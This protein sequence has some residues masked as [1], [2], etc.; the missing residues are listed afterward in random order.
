MEDSVE[1]AGDL[2]AGGALLRP[3]GPGFAVPLRPEGTPPLDLG[4]RD[5]P[6]GLGEGLILARG[7]AAT[8]VLMRAAEGS[9]VEVEVEVEDDAGTPLSG[10]LSGAPR[11]SGGVME[12]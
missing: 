9:E 10:L 4:L 3:R 5:R 11:L 2:V 12:V 8:R 7:V 6:S 1:A